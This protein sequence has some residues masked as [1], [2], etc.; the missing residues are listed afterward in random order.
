MLD[1]GKG[2]MTLPRPRKLRNLSETKYWLLSLLSNNKK[3][4]LAIQCCIGNITCKLKSPPLTQQPYCKYPQLPNHCLTRPSSPHKSQC[5]S[6]D[7]SYNIVIAIIRRVGLHFSILLGIPWL[8]K[9]GLVQDPWKYEMYSDVAISDCFT[10]I[11]TSWVAF[12]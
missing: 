5:L 11:T 4:K 10:V 12:L 8:A 1:E 3:G 6:Q 7:D 2:P 9:V